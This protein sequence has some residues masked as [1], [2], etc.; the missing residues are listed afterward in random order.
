MSWNVEGSYKLHDP[1]IIKYLQTSDIFCVLETWAG[2]NVE[3]PEVEG[4]APIARIDAKKYVENG[5]GRKS[6]GIMLYAKLVIC[7]QMKKIDLETKNDNAVWIEMNSE[8]DR[9]IF[10]FV[11]NPPEDSKYADPN[12]F[13]L[14][15]R[16]MCEV[17]H[18]AGDVPIVLMGDFNGRVGMCEDV[19]DE[20]ED[21]VYATDYF[22]NLVLDETSEI[23]ERASQDTKVNKQGKKLVA[24]CQSSGC[25]IVNGRSASDI[26][27][28][29]TFLAPGNRKSVID[30]A[31]IQRKYFARIKDMEVEERA[32]S[33]HLPI[34]ITVYMD[35]IKRDECPENSEGVW[36]KTVKYKFC[37]EKENKV[38]KEI[39][40]AKIIFEE[41]WQNALS[42]NGGLE[43]FSNVFDQFTKRSFAPLK[44]RKGK[45][46][47][48][49][50]KV[51]VVLGRKTR[52]ALRQFRRSRTEL[53][54]EE[55][56]KLKRTLKM[57]RVKERLDDEMKRRSDIS[58]FYKE[59]DWKELWGLVKR[60]MGS[61]GRGF[62][63]TTISSE[64]WRVH[65][66]ELYN[67]RLS[68]SDPRWDDLSGCKEEVQSLD[69]FI[70]KREILKAMKGMKNNKAAGIDGIPTDLYKLFKDHF[71]GPMCD[72]FNVIMEKEA[73][74]KSW[75]QAVILPL[76]KNKGSK[77]NV[78][79]FR[80]IG[81]LNCIGKI[82]T[83]V[84]NE[85]MRKW[86]CENNILS[87]FQAG[88]RSNHSTIDQ[89]FVLNTI[90]QRRL[91]RRKPTYCV[92]VDFAKAFDSV[93]RKALWFKLANQGISRKF[94]N[95][96]RSLYE[97]SSFAIKLGEDGLSYPLAS[98]TGVLQGSQISPSCFIHFL[99]DLPERLDMVENSYAPALGEEE[100]KILLF[101]DD[102]CLLS[103]SPIGLQR[104][105]DELSRYCLEW[106]LKVNVAKT[107]VTVF[108]GSNRRTQHEKWFYDGEELETVFCFKYLGVNFTGNG[109]WAQ[110]SLKTVAAAK[111][112]V[113]QLA[114][115]YYK[116]RE[117]SLKLFIHLYKAL[118]E[119]ALLYGSEVFAWSCDF[120][121]GD[122][123]ARMFFK[124]ILGLP[125]G[126]QST[127]LD[128][129][130]GRL[131]LANL[132][133]IR[134][135]SYWLKVVNMS[136]SRVVKMAYNYQLGL[137]EQGVSCWA[138]D[139][140]GELRYLNLSFIWEDPTALSR[141]ITIKMI[142][143]AREKKTFEFM[144]EE[145]LNFESCKALSERELRFGVFP[146]LISLRPQKRRLYAKV[147]L[148]CPG[149][150]VI[151]TD[152]VKK[153]T[154]CKEEVKY[155]V[156]FHRLI[157][158]SKLT[159][160]RRK[161]EEHHCLEGIGENNFETLLMLIS[162]SKYIQLL[163]KDPLE[164]VGS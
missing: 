141:K 49:I 87:K 117:S 39:L 116:N 14:I 92:W 12:F 76:F 142:K 110:H 47:N 70:A 108:K 94:L 152:K 156:F 163:F 3:T 114:K 119:P 56:I 75:G 107:K 41:K 90:V 19:I 133:R 105:L 164:I 67:V 45:S 60:N 73:T 51:S 155:N 37:E 84:M 9:A 32:E 20:D 40:S 111:R 66:D 127:G 27:G 55:Y 26:S 147:L 95:I 11:Y 146:E 123:V 15:Q 57:Q 61:K 29:F 30:Y 99:N 160:E 25:V 36:K 54:L 112:N 144:K 18:Y 88:F 129:I 17:I 21:R 161:V 82:F 162:H 131:P 1:E 10:A 2:K 91:Q 69:E 158:C 6:G 97:H 115:F 138:G 89:I 52:R 103:N 96:L 46:K 38:L 126:A 31:L 79:S 148:N 120:S 53:D 80:G 42:R 85:R 118:I 62:V 124:Q 121:R 134:A 135:L 16:Q 8:K 81:L 68:D 78:N 50:E 64:Q 154:L 145:I 24:F 125:Q 128:I 151:R 106:N 34:S 143:Q 13:D 100:I 132:A 153:C 65:F 44:V 5:R 72:L 71:L 22:P 157:S 93:D 58:N 7:E 98:K 101:A 159:A 48:K 35:C 28:N 137:M 104:L 59:H 149:N 23:G 63:K 150:L 83:K 33:T 136:D 113:F 140:K 130:I 77:N 122:T 74:P 86:G 43:V 109:Q 4:Y 102:A 139:V